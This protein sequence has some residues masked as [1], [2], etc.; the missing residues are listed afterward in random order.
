M[1]DLTVAER[2]AELVAVT[3]GVCAVWDFGRRWL[4][5]KKSNELF[6]AKVEQVELKQTLR[7]NNQAANELKQLVE[8]AEAAAVRNDK[9]LT[10]F[11]KQVLEVTRYTERT[12]REAEGQA[13]SN[14]GRRR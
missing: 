1:F 2:I 11:L 5:T 12:R 6:D 3:G 10:E 7:Y 13:M 9:A 14:A 8:R 4:Q